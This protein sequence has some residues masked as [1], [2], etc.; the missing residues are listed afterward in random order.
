M[1]RQRSGAADA[2]ELARASTPADRERVRRWDQYVGVRP[3][4]V[5]LAASLSEQR[6][7]WIR[8]LEH[9]ASPWWAQH[10]G[11]DPKQHAY[12]R[13]DPANGDLQSR[14]LHHETSCTV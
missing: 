1:G 6:S 10:L 11:L 2:S 12:R 3:L 4:R 5:H 13:C 14:I 9:G 7:E 8:L